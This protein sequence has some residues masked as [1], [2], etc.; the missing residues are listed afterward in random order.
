MDEVMKRRLVGIGVLSLVI[1]V[2]AWWLP[3]RNDGQKR[4]N[5]ERLPTETRVY[6]IHALNAEPEAI[7][8]GENPEAGAEPP[9]NIAPEFGQ[10]STTEE[11]QPAEAEVE[12]VAP[13]PVETTASRSAIPKP[14]TQPAA[15]PAPKPATV[16]ISKPKP[17][18]KPTTVAKTEPKPVAKP[19]PAAKPVEKPA[20][21]PKP[22]E[23]EAKKPAQTLPSGGWV[24]QVGSYGKQANADGMRKKLEA[25]GYRVIVTSSQV[26]GKTFHR[27]RVGPYPTKTDAQ[28][29]AKN[30]EK[31][32]G[33][34]VVVQSNS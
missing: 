28:G 23:V 31:M 24:I 13:A 8:E 20:E 33:Q 10:L 16:T 12:T 19:K 34:K 15:K 30:L 2:V 7:A 5:P 14:S 4:L 11:S 9:P 29:S 6:D 27:V 17:A 18:P 22:A 32:L 25:K 1:L 3:D 26:N 21:T